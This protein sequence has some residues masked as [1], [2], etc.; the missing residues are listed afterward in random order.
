MPGFVSAKTFVA[1][2]GE[3]VTLVEF[4]SPETQAAW[5]DHPEHRQAQAAGR[6]AFYSEYALQV[7]GVERESRFP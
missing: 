7:C 5:R 4:D 6:D 2:D 3:R 1:E